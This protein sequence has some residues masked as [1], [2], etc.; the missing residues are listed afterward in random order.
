M[1][2]ICSRLRYH[3]LCMSRNA[4]ILGILCVGFVVLAALVNRFVAVRLGDSEASGAAPSVEQQQRAFSQFETFRDSNV[5]AEFYDLRAD[6]HQLTSKTGLPIPNLKRK[7]DEMA[8]CAGPS[9][10]DGSS[11]IP[12]VSHLAKPNIVVIMTDDQNAASM[13]VMEKI[14][15]KLAPRATNFLNSFVSYSGCCPSR[16]TFLTGQYA[17]NHGVWRNGAPFGG[18]GKLDHTRTLPV[19]LQGAGYYTYHIG[20]YLNQYGIV[21]ATPTDGTD[22]QKEIPPGWNDWHGSIDNTTYNYNTYKLNENG[23]ITEY[24]AYQTDTYAEKAVNFIKSRAGNPQPFF[25]NLSFTAP[26]SSGASEE[27]PG[28]PVPAAR[29][30]GSFATRALPRPLSFN[31]SDTG[32]KVSA[33]SGLPLL[34]DAEVAVT[35]QRYQKRLETLQAVD[36]AV[37]SIFETLKATNQLNKT[38][39]V[40]TSDNGFLQGEHRLVNSK[41]YHY[42]PSIRVPLLIAI[43]GVSARRSVAQLVTNADLTATI[44]DLADAAPTVPLDGKS[45][46]P[47]M[48]SS[49]ADGAWRK[50]FLVET[51]TYRGIRDQNSVYVEYPAVPAQ[52]PDGKPKFSYNRN[53]VQNL[54]WVVLD[55]ATSTVDVA[56]EVAPVADQL[57]RGAV[58]KWQVYQS[59][60]NSPEYVGNSNLHRELTCGGQLTTDEASMF[61]LRMYRIFLNKDTA[62]DCALFNAWLAELRAQPS[63]TIDMGPIYSIGND[64]KT[65]RFDGYDLMKPN[66]RQAGGIFAKFRLV[67]SDNNHFKIWHI[68]GSDRKPNPPD[69]PRNVDTFEW[70]GGD[71]YYTDTYNYSENPDNRKHV[72]YA[73]GH[74]YMKRTM[75]PGVPVTSTSVGSL[76]SFAFRDCDVPT[77]ETEARPPRNFRMTATVYEHQVAWS[78]YTGGIDKPVPVIRLD[79]LTCTNPSGP[80]NCPFPFKEEW[81]YYKDPTHGYVPIHSVGYNNGI[82]IWNNRLASIDG[83]TLSSPSPTPTPT[84]TPTSTPPSFLR[85][86]SVI[87]SYA[88]DGDLDIYIVNAHGHKRL[89]VNPKIFSLYGHLTGGYAGV[90]HTAPDVRDAYGTS[91]L[92]RNC[93]INDQKVWALEVL[94][95]DVAVLHHVNVPGDQ[96]VKQDP[97]F[98]RKVF[99]INSREQA[100]YPVSSVAY[101]HVNQIPNYR[102]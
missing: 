92:F 39:I 62:P 65:L 91:G 33:I 90:I 48:K 19:W 74:L 100:L 96:A 55:R 63:A 5:E 79:E 11:A 89:F 17:H 2:D 82:R 31:E 4:T 45:L 59:F 64:G 56:K 43:P 81:Y 23:T 13:E 14:K 12:P 87:S 102:R 21:D 58:S 37:E 15:A 85:E 72:K 9:C 80:N 40:F 34:S 10:W 101:T 84:A 66:E 30:E 88:F 47:L 27:V 29:H 54:Y 57:D 50:S 94:S 52:S 36:E 97:N 8:R 76:Y 38:V 42:E 69:C 53:W 73:P 35:E 3:K 24:A 46:L 28:A 75:R 41:F 49:A 16:A 70:R 1:L 20:K 78:S 98:F 67:F 99:C 32:D 25:L 44:A 68:N 77:D 83:G 26:H 86:G 61:V 71:L 6:P 95:E 22:P 93:E 51:D 7:L 60:I 18:Y